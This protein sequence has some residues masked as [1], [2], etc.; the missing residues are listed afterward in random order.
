M[1][2]LIQFTFKLQKDDLKMN[3]NTP[4]LVEGSDVNNVIAS[5]NNLV[6]KMFMIYMY[7]TYNV[8]ISIHMWSEWDYIRGEWPCQCTQII[9]RVGLC[10]SHVQSKY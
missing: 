1:S 4:V 9:I 2:V 6:L 5:D 7:R 3:I 8:F 10:W